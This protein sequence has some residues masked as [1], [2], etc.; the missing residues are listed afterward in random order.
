MAVMKIGVSGVK[1]KAALRRKRKEICES[2][3]ENGGGNI[4][5]R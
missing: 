5:K 4:E 2:K 1:S 3:Y